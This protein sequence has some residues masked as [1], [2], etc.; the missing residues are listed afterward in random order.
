LSLIEEHFE[1]VG[2]DFVCNK[3]AVKFEQQ[4]FRFINYWN[5]LDDIDNKKLGNNRLKNFIIKIL[6]IKFFKN[7]IKIILKPFYM[8]S[9]KIVSS[10]FIFD[11]ISRIS[12]KYFPNYSKSGIIIIGRKNEN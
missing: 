4:F 12:K 1:I 9:Y 3:I 2:Y 6:Q 5:F 10:K 7:I 8:I 11:F